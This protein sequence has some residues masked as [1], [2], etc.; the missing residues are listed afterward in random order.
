MRF[1]SLLIATLL[2][3]V[4]GSVGQFALADT[5]QVSNTT[6][7]SYLNVKLT[8]PSEIL[9][10]QSVTVNIQAT[11]RD[12]FNL[13]SLT[14][15]VY[16]A[17]GNDLRQLT[18]STVAK[19][20][21]MSRGN[22]INKDLQTTVPSDAP[23]TSLIALVSETARVTY[24]D[25]SYYYMYSPYYYYYP[26][27]YG[28]YSYYYAYYPSYSYNSVTDDGIA[29]LSYIKAT[30]PEY[31][32]LQTEYQM[33]QQKLDQS[34]A[35]NQQLTQTL[36]ARQATIDQLNSQITDLSQQLDS[37]RGTVTGLEVV[38]VILAG[39]VVALVIYTFRERNRR[40]SAAAPTPN[41]PTT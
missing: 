27:Y 32:S 31:V 11:A 40:T 15:Q 20:L 1:S 36:N 5:T 25:Y 13:H 41:P 38:S 4:V 26:S 7:L 21:Y 17:D 24:Y 8:Y 37:A 16:F 3:L 19:D 39:I 34:Q 29:P 18:S 28:N 33:L 22:Q 35:Q 10:G 2:V 23:R 6:S 12:S 9:P 30:T 14:V